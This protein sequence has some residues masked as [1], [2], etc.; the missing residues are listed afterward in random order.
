[1]LTYT[2]RASLASVIITGGIDVIWIEAQGEKGDTGNVKWS[3][4]NIDKTLCERLT[5][6]RY[7][8]QWAGEGEQRLGSKSNQS[9]TLKLRMMR[10]MIKIM[11]H[12][13]FCVLELRYY[14]PSPRISWRFRF[15]RGR[16]ALLSV[17]IYISNS[18]QQ[19][20]ASPVNLR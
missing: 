5:I 11:K 6:Y 9:W 4:H 10:L 20:S 3:I 18:H 2:A 12:S 1:M 17:Q 8:Y 19:R 13:A 7:P 14:L 15:P 16:F